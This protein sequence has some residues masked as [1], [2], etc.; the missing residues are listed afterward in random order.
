MH[1]GPDQILVAVD[2]QFAPGLSTAMRHSNPKVSRIFIEAA[3]IGA[4][5]AAK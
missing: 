2:I 4:G 3:S 1:F 5:A